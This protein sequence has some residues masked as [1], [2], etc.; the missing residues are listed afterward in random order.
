MPWPEVSVKDQRHLRLT[1]PPCRFPSCRRRPASR[2]A[3][4]QVPTGQ[5]IPV[6]TGMTT[7]HVVSPR[8]R[9]DRRCR[10]KAR[11]P[12]ERI[13]P[14]ANTSVTYLPERVSTMSPD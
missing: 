5:W 8:S 14:T 10:R 12:M 9:R 4:P 6:F 1:R 11:Q 2:S 7:V 3:S 13:K